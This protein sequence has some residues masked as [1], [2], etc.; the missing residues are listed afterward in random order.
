M[1][2]AQT[3]WYIWSDDGYISQYTVYFVISF[4]LDFSDE[5]ER[6][7]RSDESR[8]FYWDGLRWTV[9]GLILTGTGS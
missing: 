2:H 1:E 3:Y 8:D 4:S 5:N 6:K 7:L 9:V